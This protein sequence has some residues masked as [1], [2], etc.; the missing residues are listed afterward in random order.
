MQQFK[1]PHKLGDVI[2]IN[3]PVNKIVG[4]VVAV[5]FTDDGIIKYDIKVAKDFI[6]L[7]VDN[8]LIVEPIA[9]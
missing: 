9:A 2:L 6:I 5:K 4:S 7:D 3:T 1:S 8:I